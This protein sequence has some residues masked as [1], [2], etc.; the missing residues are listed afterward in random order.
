MLE[1]YNCT[2]FAYGQT[3]TGKTHT[4]EGQFDD[5]E[6]RGI[7]PRSV[8]LIFQQLEDKKVDFSV[9]ASYLE[10]YNEELGDLL[11]DSYGE[12][13]DKRK[14]VAS[15]SKHK[16]LLLCDGEKGVVC[17]NLT[18]VN[19][20]SAKEVLD[21]LRKGIDAR[22]VAE[23]QM[24]KASSRSHSIVTLKIMIKE[25]TVNGEQVRFGQ[26]NLVDLAG[27]ECVQR[28]GATGERLR[29]A[30]N[31]NQSLLTLGRVITGLSV[32]GGGFI[33]YR[34]SKLTRL[35]QES[36]GGRAKT[37]ILATVSPADDS[38]DES[39][40]TLEYAHRARSIKNKPVTNSTSS[41]N[42]VLRASTQ[43]VEDMRKIL[44]AQREKSGTYL[45][46][47]KYEEMV[48]QI[49]SGKA[50]LDMCEEELIRLRQQLSSEKLRADGLKSD[51]AFSKKQCAETEAEL[52]T[53]KEA[54]EKT[55]IELEDTRG[56]LQGTQAIVGEQS[57]TETALTNEATVLE[58]SLTESTAD[59]TELLAKVQRASCNANEKSSV[60]S[61]LGEATLAASSILRQRCSELT[62]AISASGTDIQVG[63]Y[64]FNFACFFVPSLFHFPFFPLRLC[65]AQQQKVT[66]IRSTFLRR[67]V[68]SLTTS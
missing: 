22:Q 60:T 38:A 50:N 29:E 54:L 68:Q 21:S 46:T 9:K 45:P 14:S 52:G 8:H 30:G 63:A 51:L 32:K 20:M 24:N 67:T 37:C 13:A 4:M 58:K 66:R 27:S 47:E 55:E 28:S 1:G 49:E 34:D 10:I 62:N 33:P 2:V 59:I 5:A 15:S 11:D 26:L 53:T 36:L 25:T 42:D 56:E 23:T 43:E 6:Q 44:Q 3:G 57:T 12:A 61:K 35:L 40:S 65:S 17:N 18:E 31:I 48:Q 41:K 16:K 64:L 7:I 19:C 39:G